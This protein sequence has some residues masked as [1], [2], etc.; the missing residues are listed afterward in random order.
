MRVKA[1][2]LAILLACGGNLLA[3]EVRGI[4]NG[5][6][7][8]PAGAAI[9][10]AKVRVTNVATGVFYD[11]ATVDTGLYEVPFLDPG[12]YTVTVQAPGFETM[13]RTAIVVP[14]AKI[15]LDFKMQLGS[16]ST[17]VTVSAA[18]PLLDTTDAALGEIVAAPSF[19]DV[20]FSQYRN[21]ENYT[22][23]APGVTGQSLGTYTATG[24]YSILINGGGGALNI[25]ANSTTGQQ[26]DANE[27][28]MDGVP[29]TLPT[30]AGLVAILPTAENIQDMRVDTSME[31]ASL[32][33]TTGG[34]VIMD[35][36]SG[37]ND[38]HGTGYA[39]G[40]WTGLYANT[41]SNDRNHIGRTQ[42]LEELYGYQAGGPVSDSALVQ[43]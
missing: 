13:Q 4:I 35:K 40:R 31:D 26:G 34:V 14:Q 16:A 17:V 20:V 19:Q 37:S 25:G 5:D 15:T 9:S 33:R 32:G 30:S 43:R 7:T 2:V 27:W 36:K 6:V 3:Q 12:N 38:F 1:L 11:T 39:Y 28:I 29:V 10:G 8:D 18:S 42:D 41:W 24:S 22:R 23:F 21:A